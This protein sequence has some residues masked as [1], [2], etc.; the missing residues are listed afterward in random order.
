VTVQSTLLLAGVEAAAGGEAAGGEAA[1]GELVEVEPL[2]GEDVVGDPLLGEDVAGVP[3]L[4]EDVA[5]ASAVELLEADSFPLGAGLGAFWT[6]MTIPASKA[7]KS[8]TMRATAMMRRARRPLSMRANF[9]NICEGPWKPPLCSPPP[10]P[11][12]EV[13]SAMS[14]AFAEKRQSI[15]EF[16]AAG[17]I[18]HANQ[19]LV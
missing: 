19:F 15:M 9:S 18:P 3:L 7:V 5:G 12:R 17:S 1:G 4:G 8:M 6:A 10:K 11:K 14:E 2:L 13:G 16:L